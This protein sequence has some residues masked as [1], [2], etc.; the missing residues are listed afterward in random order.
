MQGV[1]RSSVKA[2]SLAGDSVCVLRGGVFFFF[3]AVFEAVVLK[4]APF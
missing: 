1:D 3:L 2:D 4:L